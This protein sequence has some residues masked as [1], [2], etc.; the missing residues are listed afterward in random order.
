MF[1]TSGSGKITLQ[2]LF[3]EVVLTISWLFLGKEDAI[4]LEPVLPGTCLMHIIMDNAL[5]VHF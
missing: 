3:Q 5:R 1:Q 2:S 4:S